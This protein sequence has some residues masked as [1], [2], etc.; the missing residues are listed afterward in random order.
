[1]AFFLLDIGI[2]L[3]A[4]LVY[5]AVALLSDAARSV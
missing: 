1:M 4:A 5:L 3:A 2:S